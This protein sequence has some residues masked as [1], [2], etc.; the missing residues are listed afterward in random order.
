MTNAEVDAQLVPH[1]TNGKRCYALVHPK[2]SSRRRHRV[3]DW[4]QYC[5]QIL[6][7]VSYWHDDFTGRIALYPSQKAP[8][9]SSFFIP[10]A[11]EIKAIYHHD[12]VAEHHPEVLL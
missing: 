9:S 3:P 7:I 1:L 5:P 10:R 4:L 2:P 6:H 11:S 8:L 12:Y